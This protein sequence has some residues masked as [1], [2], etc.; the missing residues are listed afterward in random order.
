[1][2]KPFYSILL[3]VCKY[4]MNLCVNCIYFMENQL[5]V[6]KQLEEFNVLN[7]TNWESFKYFIV[8]KLN[9]L[10]TWNRKKFIKI[11]NF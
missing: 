4:G 3:A 11:F 5:A 9:T 1:M 10:T 8:K 7:W 2:S 6:Y